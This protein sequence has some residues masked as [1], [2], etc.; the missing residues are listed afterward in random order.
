M[1]LCWKEQELTISW[2]ALAA[3]EA[4]E[5]D[6]ARSGAWC[7]LRYLLCSAWEAVGRKKEGRGAVRCELF[8]WK[9]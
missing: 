2:A 9:G 3:E 8:T 6:Q 5:L 1:P 4:R 7:M